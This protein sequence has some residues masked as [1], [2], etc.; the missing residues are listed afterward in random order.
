[1][2]SFLAS[3]RRLKRVGLPAAAALAALGIGLMTS[4]QVPAEA[5]DKYTVQTGGGRAGISVDIFR[6]SEI[7]VAAGDTIEFVNPYE[8][9]HT[10]TYLQGATPSKSWAQISAD[11]P[12]IIPLGPAP[13]P[14]VAPP[15]GPPKLGISPKVST[16]APA[17]GAAK[18]D[19]T[20]YQNS[21]IVMK[22]QSWTASFPTQGAYRLICVLHPMMQVDV[23]VLPAGT[24]VPTQAQL[25]AASTVS[26]NGLVAKGEAKAA[27]A[28]YGSSTN[29]NGTKNWDVVSGEFDPPSTV[30]RFIPA[31]I[32]VGLGDTVNWVNQTPVPHTIT[33]N[34]GGQASFLPEPQPSGPPL[35]VIDPKAL[36]PVVPSKNFDGSGYVNSGFIG[37]G[38]E[39]TAGTSFSLTFTKAGTY[40]YVCLLHAD[41]GMAGVIEVGA[42]GT[43]TGS[44]SG[45]G[46]R[47][48][49]TGDGGLLPDEGANST[50]F[51]AAGSVMLLLA[52]AAM[53]RFRFR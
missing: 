48:P 41:Q 32:S 30:N 23:Q 25:D 4:L 13:L 38:E 45:G 27:A 31:R 18:I 49:S 16:P 47:P 11:I 9:I 43:G 40:S 37:T 3:A 15:P 17:S 7:L 8:E 29:A 14:G 34:S 28:K 10:I 22:G 20:A 24:D 44:G 53:V 2:A 51:Y 36:F 6:P 26:L 35:L 46:I 39:A 21:G 50:Y 19:G 1:M 52:A 12:F 42:A 33:F 5:A